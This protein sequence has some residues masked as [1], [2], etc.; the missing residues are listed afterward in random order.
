MTRVS[1][2]TRVCHNLFFN[3]I[4]NGLV[5][6]MVLVWPAAAT[7]YTIVDLGSVQPYGVNSSGQVVGYKVAASGFFHAVLCSGGV[8]HDLGTLGGTTSYAFGIDDGGQVVGQ[9]YNSSGYGHAFLYSG[10]TMN[11]LGTF[12]GGKTSSANCINNNGDYAGYGSTSAGAIYGFVT[13]GIYTYKLAANTTVFGVNFVSGQSMPNV[14]GKYSNG[15]P[16]AYGVYFLGDLGGT[17]GTYY[18]INDNNQV[19]GVAGTAGN[20]EMHAIVCGTGTVTDLNAFGAT[21]SQANGI[22]NSGRVVGT[23]GGL[24]FLYEDGVVKDL[25]TLVP[26][27]TGWTLG[28]ANA[29]SSNGLIAG[30]GSLNGVGHAFL[31]IPNDLT[32]NLRID[33][34]QVNANRETDLFWS[35]ITGSSFNVL[36]STNAK[37]PLSQ[38]TILGTSIETD[39]GHFRYHDADATNYPRRFYRVSQ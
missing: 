11:D 27:G 12:F 6:A 19:C 13:S 14:V 32:A 30:S 23:S 37:A 36:A 7:T 39:L 29:I 24:A 31:L 16:L 22:N 33:S 3:A 10:G 1:L 34:L 25:N 35:G 4:L 17:L 38:W 15:K 26:S 8:I 28:A 9:A 18:G 20:A 5:L 2:R 21:Q